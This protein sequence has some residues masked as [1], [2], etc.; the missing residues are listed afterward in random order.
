MDMSTES[1]RDELT[2][3]VKLKQMQNVAKD[4]DLPTSTLS[5]SLSGKYPILDRFF[6]IANQVDREFILV[7][8][9]DNGIDHTTQVEDLR[10][11][12]QYLANLLDV[13]YPLIRLHYKGDD[14]VDT[15][16][17]GMADEIAELRTTVDFILQHMNKYC[18]A[19]PDEPNWKERV[20]HKEF[21]E[22][23][24]PLIKDLET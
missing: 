17:K 19:K 11:E 16:L 7:K 1:I 12:N 24:E 15:F 10:K 6:D 2:R 8:K 5:E 3:L 21:K 23:I 20:C 9:T 4:L 18:V 22:H 14:R 13:L